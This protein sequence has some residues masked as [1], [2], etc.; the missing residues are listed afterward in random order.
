MDFLRARTKEQ[1]EQRQLDIMKAC[2]TLFDQGG[3][4]SVNIKAIAEMTT[5]NRSSIYTYYKTREEILLDLLMEELL[6][7]KENL[8]MWAKKHLP[9]SR[10]Q[11]SKQ[12]TK[13]LKDR[14]K[15]LSLYCLLYNVLERNCRIEHLV[16]FKKRAVPVAE[17]VVEC[18]ITNYPNCDKKEAFYTAHEIIS[19]VLGLY[20]SSHLTQKQKEAVSLSATGYMEPDFLVL[21]QRG[22]YCFLEPLENRKQSKEKKS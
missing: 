7:W 9:L 18:L 3:Y 1:I 16:E 8:E 21:C 17:M 6:E 2:D 15:M 22:I 20:P 12:F 14:D 11:F 10:E 13:T 19:Y 4:E 5:I